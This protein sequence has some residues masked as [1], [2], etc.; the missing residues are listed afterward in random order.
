ME[1]IHGRILS[2][3]MEQNNYKFYLISGGGRR[4]GEGSSNHA[5]LAFTLRAT[6]SL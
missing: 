5:N 6:K 1:Y 2:H 4:G 3:S